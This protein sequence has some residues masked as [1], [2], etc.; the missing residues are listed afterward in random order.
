MS[1]SASAPDILIFAWLCSSVADIL[2][3]HDCFAPD[4]MGVMA[5]F[6]TLSKNNK[7]WIH[8]LAMFVSLHADHKTLCL[9]K[10][11]LHTHWNQLCHAMI[12]LS[13]AEWLLCHQEGCWMACSVRPA[14]CILRQLQFSSGSCHAS[15]SV[16]H[17]RRTG[18]FGTD[19]S[20]CGPTPMDNLDITM[21]CLSW[22]TQEVDN[23]K[24]CVSHGNHVH[25]ILP[26]TSS[27]LQRCPWS[28]GWWWRRRLRWWWVGGSS[29]SS[30]AAIHTN[31]R[32]FFSGV[33]IWLTSSFRSSLANHVSR[34][35]GH[36][37]SLCRT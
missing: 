13:F 3:L 33:L 2:I 15:C 6:A 22:K 23:V 32:R 4:G 30:A 12:S 8:A 17:Q 10:W 26:T 29:P 34:R 11:V 19:T 37:V 24:Q 9:V 36:G 28:L 7:N 21:L 18:K 5:D 20:F 16:H 14:L 31:L 35:S 1:L 27:W 25:D